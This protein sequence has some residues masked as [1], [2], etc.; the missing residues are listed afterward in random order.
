[1]IEIIAEMDVIRR[2]T[3]QRVD[4]MDGADKIHGSTTIERRETVTVDL[5]LHGRDGQGSGHVNMESWAPS[6]YRG[7]VDAFA[8]FV[9]LGRDDEIVGADVR[10]GGSAEEW[11]E[12]ADRW[13]SERP[14]KSVGDALEMFKGWDETSDRDLDRALERAQEA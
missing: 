8:R 1:M 5:E 10:M 9:D 2:E 11:I 3:A 4:R 6:D 14:D 7:R 12:A 13:I